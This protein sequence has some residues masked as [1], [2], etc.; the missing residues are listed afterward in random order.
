VA[1][2]PSPYACK[3]K[4]TENTAARS[5]PGYAKRVKP[6]KAS[7]VNTPPTFPHLSTLN[8]KALGLY[9]TNAHPSTRGYRC[10]TA[11]SKLRG[12]A[13]GRFRRAKSPRPRRQ[14]RP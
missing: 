14:H 7:P 9:T 10:F 3:P 5:I 12:T 13:G 11:E 6:V 1:R 8:L 2:S 4:A